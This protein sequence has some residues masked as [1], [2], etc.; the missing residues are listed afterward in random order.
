MPPESV[1]IVS[2]AHLGHAP[3][4]VARSFHAF[5]ETVPQLGRHLIINGDLFDFWFEYRRVISREAFPTLSAL[6]QVRTA[7]VELT[8]TGGNHDRWGGDFWS[9]ELGARFYP[10]P[11][12]LD[13]LGFRVFLAHGDGLSETRVASRLMHRV[14]RLPV[15]VGL[16]RWIHPDIGF[17]LA[18]RMSGSLA[19]QTRDAAS[20]DRAASAQRDYA[21]A[22]LAGRPDLN[23]VVLGHTHRPQLDAAGPRRWFL[24][25]GAW[26]ESGAY[27]LLTAAGPELRR[28]P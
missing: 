25:P 3:E 4:S 20:L 21:R 26:M 7:G 15:T 9:R 14:T 24:N 10:I 16:F 18:D 2:D 22:L 27:A 6:L 28:F 1:L 13:L 11:V 5:L 12:E 17:W 23:L 19:E 8:V